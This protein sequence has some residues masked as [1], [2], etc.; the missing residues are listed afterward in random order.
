MLMYILPPRPC[1]DAPVDILISPLAPLLVVPD[2]NERS[3][4]TPCVPE[5]TV[6][7][8]IKPELLAVPDPVLRDT[9]P[10]VALA[11]CPPTNVTCPPN[12]TVLLLERP[13]VM[14]ILPP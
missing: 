10:P 7:I 14:V 12:P 9:E 3:P 2:L 6:F 4:L 5:L 8:A 13:A 11:P 1:V